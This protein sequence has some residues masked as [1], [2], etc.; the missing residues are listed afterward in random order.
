[1]DQAQSDELT[2]CVA[3]NWHRTFHHLYDFLKGKINGRILSIEQI[4]EGIAEACVAAYLGASTPPSA[5]PG[6][7]PTRREI[8][9]GQASR[10]T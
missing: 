9:K 8:G 4:N 10:F 7:S 3:S 2:I 6:I 5:L 1:M